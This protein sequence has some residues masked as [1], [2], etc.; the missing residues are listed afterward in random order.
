MIIEN[1]DNIIANYFNNI[2][3]PIIVLN[4]DDIIKKIE[5]VFLEV[6]D[7]ETLVID[8]DTSAADI[9]AWDSLTHIRLIISIETAFDLQ[10]STLDIAELQN[11]GD[12]A[13]L[14]LS[15]S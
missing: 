14:I 6:F 12:L 15:K 2:S 10:F 1:L 11:V 9:E 5:P 3:I 4:L 13:H 8:E 7:D